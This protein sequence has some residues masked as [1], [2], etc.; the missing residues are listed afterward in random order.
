MKSKRIRP[1]KKIASPGIEFITIRYEWVFQCSCSLDN[2]YHYLEL[3]ISTVFVVLCSFVCACAYPNTTSLLLTQFNFIL[4]TFT[5]FCM[6]CCCLL[7]K[8]WKI[9]PKSSKECQCGD[10]LCSTLS[11]ANLSCLQKS[12]RNSIQ[13][14]CD[15]HFKLWI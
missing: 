4:H 13:N 5:L 6:N 2:I 14:M 11:E 12:N 1:F 7:V 10:N 9:N 8:V 15:V 3:W